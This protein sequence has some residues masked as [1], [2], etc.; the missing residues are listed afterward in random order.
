[1]RLSNHAQVRMQQRAIPPLIAEWLNE[2]G[3]TSYDKHGA[4]RKFFDK[5]SRKRLRKIV[6]KQVV[7]Q[8][9]KELSAYIVVSTDDTVI[10]AGYRTKRI[11]R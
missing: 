4:M 7:E 8:L 2:Y 10:T 1:M 6:G 11:R 5:R 9:S 3:S